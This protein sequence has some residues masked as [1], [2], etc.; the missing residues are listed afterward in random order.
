[1]LS[2]Y[3][4]TKIS[5]C[6]VLITTLIPLELSAQTYPPTS[7][8]VGEG[9][10]ASGPLVCAFNAVRLAQTQG[11]DGIATVYESSVIERL[12]QVDINKVLDELKTASHD[13]KIRITKRN[14]RINFS[15]GGTVNIDSGI[16]VSTTI[17]VQQTIVCQQFPRPAD[18]TELSCYFQVSAEKF[19]CKNLS[20]Q[21]Q[22]STDSRFFVLHGDQLTKLAS[23]A[24][25]VVAQLLIARPFV[26]AET[27]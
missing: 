24:R 21:S 6:A 14:P 22:D 10:A 5:L 25:S 12:N 17:S 16:L 7:L 4:G 15:C 8:P 2:N 1:M 11:V 27:P 13:A 18:A 3:L 19:L 26:N 20:C 23:E 9:L